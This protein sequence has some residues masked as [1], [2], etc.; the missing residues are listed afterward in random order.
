[1]G[2]VLKLNNVRL[3]FPH[4]FVPTKYKDQGDAK[5]R[6]VFILGKDHPQFMEVQ[7]TILSVAQGAWGEK[8]KARLAAIKNNPQKFCWRDGDTKPDTDGFP[9]NFFLSTTSRGR[10]TVWDRDLSPLTAEEGRPYGGCYVN[11]IVDIYASNK[12]GDAISAGLS[13]VQ[14]VRDGDAFGGAA[15][16]KASDFS[17][18]EGADAPDMSAVVD[19]DIAF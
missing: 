9:G 8:A 5:F 14:F 6:A 15:P 3:A 10:P 4:L 11:A 13:G 18:V 16:A 19:D 12:M 17:I 7:K 1:M 2:T